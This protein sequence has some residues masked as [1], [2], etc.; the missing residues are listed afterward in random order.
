MSWVILMT[1]SGPQQ[2]NELIDIQRNLNERN[3]NLMAITMPADGLAPLGARPSAGMVMTW[4][5][6]FKYTGSTL[7]GILIDV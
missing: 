6:S 3:S 2:L 4:F 1:S 5:E 7:N